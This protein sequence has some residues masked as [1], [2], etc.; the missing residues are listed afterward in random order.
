MRRHRVSLYCTAAVLAALCLPGTAAAAYDFP[1]EA[2]WPL[3]EG[4]GQTIRDWSGNGN[5]GTLGSTAGVDANDP[6]WIKGIFPWSSALHFDGDDFVT[7]KDSNDLESQTVTVSAWFR[8]NGSPG[9]FKH[10]VAKGS[11]ECQ[12]G[13]YGLYTGDGGGM[14]FYV[15]SLENFGWTRAPE[16]PT[17]VW[18]G[19]WHNATG[20]FDGTTVRL[21]IDGKQIGTGTSRTEPIDYNTP[22]GNANLGAYIGTCD[23]TLTGDLDE[24]SIWSKALPVAEI[25]QK[26]SIFFQPH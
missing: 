6:S 25:W 15:S 7:I 14:G 2:Y 18:D 17:T 5:N 12:A 26:A 9:R 24:V 19:K 20:T 22:N 8:G 11:N 23:L 16:A 10:L 1:L 21:F 13:A 4:K 3:N